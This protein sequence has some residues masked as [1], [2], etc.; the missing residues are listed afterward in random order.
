MFDGCKTASL[1]MMAFTERV[2]NRE[3][4]IYG[5]K[6]EIR[7]NGDNVILHEFTSESSEY[8]PGINGAGHDYAD[9]QLMDAFVKAVSTNDTSKICTGV[10]EILASHLLVFAAEKARK[11]NRVITLNDDYSCQ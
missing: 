6:G 8:F 4:V 2:C 10:Q 5:T 9:F 11:E 3:T 7:Y 1:T